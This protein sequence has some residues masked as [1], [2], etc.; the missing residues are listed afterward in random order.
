MATL[1][2][3]SSSGKYDVTPTGQTGGV[4]TNPSTTYHPPADPNSPGPGFYGG[5]TANGTGNGTPPQGSAP[6]NVITGSDGTQQIG[7]PPGANPNGATTPPSVPSVPTVQNPGTSSTP[8]SLTSQPAENVINDLGAYL[9]QRSGLLSNDLSTL[10]NNYQTLSQQAAQRVAQSFQLQQ[11]QLQQ[12]QNQET[13]T[14]E[15]LQANLGRSG[16]AQGAAETGGLELLQNQK[17]TQL[18]LSEQSA[19]AEAQTALRN[20]E[21]SRSKELMDRADQQFQERAKLAEM[22]QTQQFKQADLALAQANFNLQAK[23]QIFD[24][25]QKLLEY[26]LNS[27]KFTFDQKNAAIQNALAEQRIS[28]EQAQNLRM[29]GVE[30]QR[31]NLEGKSVITDPVFGKPMIWDKN[32]MTFTPVD[33][34]VG[35]SSSSSGGDN[36][37]LGA[38]SNSGT[39]DQKGVGSNNS[40]PSSPSP[41]S[42]KTLG[43]GD[44]RET[45][46][47]PIF[48][49]VRSMTSQLNSD[50]QQSAM[51]EI[52]TYIT[53]K[54]IP[55]LKEEIT[56]M[57]IKN[58]DPDAKK[59][60]FGRIHLMNQLSQ[61]KMSLDAYVKKTGD[62]GI[63][64][65]NFENFMEKLGT[66][67][68]PELSQ[69]RTQL[70]KMTTDFNHDLYGSR[71][72]PTEIAQ[73]KNILPDLSNVNSLNV[74]KISALVNLLNS[75]QRVDLNFAMNS[76]NYNKIFGDYMRPTSVDE[77]KTAEPDKYKDFIMS[78]GNQVVGQTEAQI[79]QAI[80]YLYYPQSANPSL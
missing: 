27:D 77:F 41:V 56:N 76:N 36:S 53:N 60:A 23:G 68:D 59:T 78:H 75:D 13:G 45:Q 35:T 71:L 37:I 8:T 46:N 21:F 55:G 19:I 18:A 15:A 40:N 11:Q 30:L 31:L 34:P 4:N 66:T 17:M 39:T 62:T 51:R 26:N 52:Q 65:S 25:N 38:F 72:T 42:L 69:I 58:L 28:V 79:L 22:M 48:Q 24:Q 5:Y 49:A 61:I 80:Q 57:A 54:D 7:S 9:G 1:T 74:G 43:T 44:I 33:L 63:V 10:H 29:Y 20:E 67:N 16:T 3:N 70:A 47:Q 73:S 64:T 50:Q 12:Q 14:N 32:S 6:Q 2:Y